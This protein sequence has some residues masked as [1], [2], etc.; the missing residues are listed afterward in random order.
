MAA[1]VAG[2]GGAMSQQGVAPPT[3]TVHVNWQTAAAS[4][5]PAPAGP[6]LAAAPETP[7][8]AAEP[9]QTKPVHHSGKK[10][11]A[12]LH[13]KPTLASAEPHH[14]FWYRLFHKSPEDR[15]AQAEP[16]GRGATR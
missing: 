11:A 15:V 5:A 10:L 3:N 16:E 2:L 12:K 8:A 14:S 13:H 1:F 7:V 9:A 6:A 4:P